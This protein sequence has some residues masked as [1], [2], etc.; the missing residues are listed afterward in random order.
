MI[1]SHPSITTDSMDEHPWT[2]LS[3]VDLEEAF[4]LRGGECARQ[5]HPIYDGACFCGDYYMFRGQKRLMPDESCY[6]D[7]PDPRDWT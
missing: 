7:P 3:E 1:L 6:S 5:G 4:W 2:G